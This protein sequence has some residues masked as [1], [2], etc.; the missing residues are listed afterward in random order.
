MAGA[1][2]RMGRES[3]RAL[4]G[5]EGVALVAAVD[6]RH[7]GEPLVDV[8]GS[9]AP[10][11]PIQTDLHL[12]LEG[13]NVLLDFTEPGSAFGNAEAALRSGVAPVVG[14]SGLS[15][16]DLEVLARLAQ[17]SGVPA[18]VV[19]NF[20]VGAVLM[21]RFAELAAK[22]MPSAE[23]VEMHHDQKLDA[24]SGTAMRTAEM[25]ASARGAVPER[26]GDTIVKSEGARGASVQTVPVHSIRLPGL[27]A[28]Q[29][30]LFGGRGETLTIRHDSLDRSSFMGGVLL[31]VR[32][33][34]NQSGLV[35]GLDRLLV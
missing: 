14:T 35:V 32:E 5:A 8:A 18:M 24:P 28:H 16:A 7:V 23:I 6:R 34:W 21:M 25:I 9:P 4:G 33:V 26:R 27:V 11:F 17:E 29:M 13:A 19:P 30:V 10:S 15:P 1:A 20:A 3:A 31:A 12:A 22:W 2:G